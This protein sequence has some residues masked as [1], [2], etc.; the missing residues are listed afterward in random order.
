MKE[1]TTPF[2]RAVLR[3]IET[4]KGKPA[5]VH[6]DKKVYVG[7]TGGLRKWAR[8]IN[9]NN[10]A[11]VREVND[12]ALIAE[13]EAKANAGEYVSRRHDFRLMPSRNVKQYK[14]WEA[15][16]AYNY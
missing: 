13:Y 10:A 2:W 9:R 8:Q 15:P 1:A 4:F 12:P 3:Q 5:L 14:Q 11:P 6:D 7:N 16:K